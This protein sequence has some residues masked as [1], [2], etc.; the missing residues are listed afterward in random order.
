MWL[1][2]KGVK[3]TSGRSGRRNSYCC[4]CRVQGAGFSLVGF[5]VFLCLFE[6]VSDLMA[7][8]TISYIVNS[9]LNCLLNV[10]S[11]LQRAIIP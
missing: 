1:V 7:V 8:L 9:S 2:R 3:R 11:V 5:V 6:R 10:K 4:S